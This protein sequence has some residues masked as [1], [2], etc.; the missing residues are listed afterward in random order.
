MINVSDIILATS[1]TRTLPRPG[2]LRLCARHPARNV[3]PCLLAV[4][5][6]VSCQGPGPHCRHPPHP[7]SSQMTYRNQARH[8]PKPSAPRSPLQNLLLGSEPTSSLVQGQFSEFYQFLPVTPPLHP[9][10]S[11][12]ASTEHLGPRPLFLSHWPVGDRPLKRGPP[13]KP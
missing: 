9:L 7:I 5:C 8:P 1:L 4:C 12:S 2:L 13:V 11:T 10:Y 6:P 3:L